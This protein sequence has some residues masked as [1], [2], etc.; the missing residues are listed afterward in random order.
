MGRH[1]IKVFFFLTD[2]TTVLTQ[3][4]GTAL[5]IT[6]GDS[7]K[8]GRIVSGLDRFGSSGFTALSKKER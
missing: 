1:F 5:M 3:L 6:F 7:V 2:L 8:I 4:A